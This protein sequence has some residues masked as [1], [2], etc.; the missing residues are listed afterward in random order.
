[1]LH[2]RNAFSSV[3]ITSVTVLEFTKSTGALEMN[4]GGLLSTVNLTVSSGDPISES[5]G[6]ILMKIS[7]PYISPRS[8]KES[9]RNV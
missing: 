5:A 2:L 4:S 3:S 6:V 8:E 1:M 9:H 7:S